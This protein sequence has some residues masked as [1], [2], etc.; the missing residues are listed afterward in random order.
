M[1]PLKVLITVSKASKESLMVLETLI[2]LD[3]EYFFYTTSSI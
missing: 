2:V 1:V 3:P